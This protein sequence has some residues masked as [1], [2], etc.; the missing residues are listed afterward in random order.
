MKA[1]EL[2]IGNYVNVPGIYKDIS[3]VLEIC[4]DRVNLSG[5]KLKFHAFYPIPLTEEWLVRLGFG[6]IQDI[7]QRHNK[8]LLSPQ[9]DKSYEVKVWVS[10]HS[11]AEGL[12]RNNRLFI[13]SVHQ[14]QNLYF[15]LTGEELTLKLENP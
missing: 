2:R 6:K 1:N 7:Y 14:L 12:S 10:N 9:S 15:A 13:R 5:L 11:F 8:L 3:E 4:E